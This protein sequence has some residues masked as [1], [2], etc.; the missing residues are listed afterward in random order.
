MAPIGRYP[1]EPPEKIEFPEV[2]SDQVWDFKD[3][4]SS[5]KAWFSVSKA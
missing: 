5:F 3:R 2:L 1:A 4:F